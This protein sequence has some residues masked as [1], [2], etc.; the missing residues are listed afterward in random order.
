MA[1]LLKRK[2]AA[3]LLGPVGLYINYCADGAAVTGVQLGGAG[4]VK[5]GCRREWPDMKCQESK[6]R[7]R[8]GNAR[9]GIV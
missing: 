9:L 2:Y 5:G 6:V 3:N 8:K 1:G 4:E 7:G